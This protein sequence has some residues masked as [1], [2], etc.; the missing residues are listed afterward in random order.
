MQ[1]HRDSLVKSSYLFHLQIRLVGSIATELCEYRE[2]AF[3]GRRQR[4]TIA[5]F[6]PARR[7]NLLATYSVL[8]TAMILF[9]VLGDTAGQ[10]VY[11]ALNHRASNP[12]PRYISLATPVLDAMSHHCQTS[13][14]TIAAQHEHKGGF[15]PVV[16][17]TH[18]YCPH[19]K[20]DSRSP[21]PALNALANHGYLPRDGKNISV[22]GLIRAL[23]EGYGLSTTLALLLSIGAVF[24]LGQFRKISLA[25]L[26]RHNLIEHDASLFHRDARK[27]QEYAPRCP[28]CSLLKAVVHQGGYYKP[29]RITL[30]DVANI[31]AKREVHGPLDFTH[32]EIARGEMAIAIGVLGG[33]N[34]DKEGLDLEVLKTW[35][36][37]ERL[38]DGWKPDHTQ[39]LYHTYKMAKVVRDRMNA[40]KSGKLKNVLDEADA[41]EAAMGMSAAHAPQVSPTSQR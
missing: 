22:F 3:G 30:E 32:A 1:R 15:C 20:G 39:G 19:H 4:I 14:S 41:T 34:A 16:G 2:I 11:K 5:V 12:H 29:G 7:W 8:P 25:D 40:I 33:P 10:T 37:Y 38:P 31:R 17:D 27:G 23:M 13:T 36:K 24:I 21:C 18:A 9:Q 28:D 26:A 6:L 35:V